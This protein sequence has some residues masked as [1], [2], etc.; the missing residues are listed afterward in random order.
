MIASPRILPFGDA[1]LLVELGGGLDPAVNAAALAIAAAIRADA[2]G[3]WGCPVPAYDTVLVPIDALAATGDEAIE[4][5][6]TLIGALPEQA[7][8][9]APDGGGLGVIE[10]PVHYGGPDGPDL[11]EV[12]GRLGLRPAQVIE[13]H[14]GTM[15]RVFFLGF[16]PGF[17][18]LGIVPDQLVVPRR[19]SPRTRVPAGSVAIAG[20]QTAVYPSAMPGG[21]NLI[22]RT[23]LATWDARRDPPALLRPG[24]AVRFVPVQV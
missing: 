5:L 6:A 17:G 15:Y 19:P 8:G 2:D 4:R 12:A 23:D 24:A 22:G 7:L 3:P 10:I 18:Y 13:A 21:W 11:E 9:P 1:A 14:A 20:A 16:A